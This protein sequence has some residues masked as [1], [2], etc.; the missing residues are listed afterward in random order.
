MNPRLLFRIATA[1]LAFSSGASAAEPAPAK[2]RESASFRFLK[3]AEVP[4][5]SVKDHGGHFV[6]PDIFSGFIGRPVRLPVREP[7]ALFRVEAKGTPTEKTPPLVS[8]KALDAPRQLVV[9]FGKPDKPE[10]R[11]IP[12]NPARFPYGRILAVNLTDTAYDAKVGDVVTRIPAGGSALCAQPDR[13][14]GTDNVAVSLYGTDIRRERLYGSVWI[15]STEI[16]TMA[17]IFKNDSGRLIVRTVQ[18]ANVPEVAEA[19]EP[20]PGP[21]K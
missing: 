7:V 18:D 10:A 14:V 20:A 15:F 3:F 17:F 4:E 2:P 13:L 6:K 16:R 21:R 8:F 1:V 19:A 12:D 9:F 11:V 5:L